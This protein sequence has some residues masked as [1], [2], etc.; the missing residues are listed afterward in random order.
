MARKKFDFNDLYR[1]VGA[2]CVQATWLEHALSDAVM[3]LAGGDT[4]VMLIVQGQRGSTSVG[5]LLRLIKD[6]VGDEPYRSSLETEARSAKGLLED[7]DRIVHSLWSK[8]SATPDGHIQSILTRTSGTTKKVWSL[9]DL[10]AVEATMYRTRLR[11]DAL[12]NNAV[13]HEQGLDLIPL[14]QLGGGDV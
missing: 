13:A 5:A 4:R 9:P 12:A 3:T 6:G 11:L 1:A 10:G 8:A 14:D 2:I 7:R